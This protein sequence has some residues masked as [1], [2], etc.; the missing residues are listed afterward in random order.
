[1]PSQGAP[2][3]VDTHSV[4]GK[5]EGVTGLHLDG[6]GRLRANVAAQVVRLEIGHRRV[7]VGVLSDFG[8]LGLALAVKAA[9]IGREERHTVL[10][11][12]KLVA[13]NR[14]LLEDVMRRGGRGREGGGE[15]AGGGL[16]VE[17]LAGYQASRS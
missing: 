13:T 8:S 4:Q 10:P 7:A 9:Q 17:L 15:K 3:G 12:T 14:E 16:H 2:Q 1:M 6:L 11:D 5:G